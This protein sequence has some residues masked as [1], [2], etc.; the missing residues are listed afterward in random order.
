MT[1]TSCTH[2]CAS[3]CAP[4]GVGFGSGLVSF[5]LLGHRLA[6]AF[7]CV[8]APACVFSHTC[9]VLCVCGCWIRLRFGFVPSLGHRLAF[10]R[11]FAPACVGRQQ[12]WGRVRSARKGFLSLRKNVLFG[13]A[14]PYMW[15]VTVWPPVSI[16]S[17]AQPPLAAHKK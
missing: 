9:V 5:P 15:K 14:N 1:G 13:H 4:V 8:F 7:V 10:V 2:T 11:V 16:D 3:C 17:G 6:F 12:F